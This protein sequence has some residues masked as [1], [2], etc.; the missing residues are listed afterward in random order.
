[1]KTIKILLSV[2]CCNTFV[3][4]SLVCDVPANKPAA[5]VETAQKKIENNALDNLSEPAQAILTGKFEPSKNSGFAKIPDEYSTRSGQYLNKRALEAFIE[6]S[7]AARKDGIELYILSATRNFNAQKSIWE[8][9]FNGTRK[10]EGKNLKNE[11]KNE[12]ERARFILRFSSMPGTSRH[13]WGTDFDISFDQ[14]N[15]SG[16]LT[17]SKYESGQGLK[18]FEW[19]QKNSAQFGFCLPYLGKPEQRRSGF[20]AGYQQEKWHWSYKPLSARYLRDFENHLEKLQPSGFD[21]DDSGKVLFKD[22][23]LNVN[24]ECL[25]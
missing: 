1:M 11:I 21:G 20:N 6:M 25:L 24:P 4:G 9:K 17:N 23:V 13:H 18:V 5:K 16:M 15:T 22:Y 10:T 19:L 14:K 12:L 7:Q 8:G 3:L 2:L